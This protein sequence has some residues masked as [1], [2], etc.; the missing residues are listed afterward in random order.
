MKQH[1]QTRRKKH[2]ALPSWTGSSVAE[3]PQCQGKANWL[4]L[5]AELINP[6]LA[7]CGHGILAS[8]K[9]GSTFR[10]PMERFQA[11]L[12]GTVSFQSEHSGLQ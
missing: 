4:S 11:L 1:P 3:S 5:S 6:S 12:P 8:K 7:Q 2:H 10:G 9:Q